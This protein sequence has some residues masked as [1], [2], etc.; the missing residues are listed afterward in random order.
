MVP[1]LRTLFLVS[2]LC[3]SGC[4]YGQPAAQASK[5]IL[6]EDLTWLQAEKVLTPQTVVV[7]PL[8]AASREHGTHL[9]NGTKK[10]EKPC[11]LSFVHHQINQTITSFLP[12]VSIAVMAVAVQ[13]FDHFNISRL[14]GFDDPCGNFVRIR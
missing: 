9:D 4:S 12:A 14:H 8:G 5:G 10:K 1:Y 6:L 2:L 11:G 3:Y 13:H 7:I